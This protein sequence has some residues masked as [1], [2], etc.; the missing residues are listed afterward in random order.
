MEQVSG[1]VADLETMGHKDETLE[2]YVKS[3]SAH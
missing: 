1:L 2:T 3:V